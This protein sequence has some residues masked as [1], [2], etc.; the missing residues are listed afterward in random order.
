MKILKIHF[1]SIF[2]LCLSFQSLMPMFVTEHGIENGSRGDWINCPSPECKKP[3]G[4]HITIGSNHQNFRRCRKCVHEFCIQCLDKWF[5]Q[6]DSNLHSCKST[7]EVVPQEESTQPI[8]PSPFVN[9]NTTLNRPSPAQ[10]PTTC[11]SDQEN[12]PSRAQT[13]TPTLLSDIRTEHRQP[14]VQPTINNRFSLKNNK[15]LVGG[16]LA[17]AG[18]ASAIFC[19]LY[20]KQHEKPHIVQQCS[21]KKRALLARKQAIRQRIVTISIVSACVL[22]GLVALSKL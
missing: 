6:G 19:T 20:K 21:S 16:V 1:L 14:P 17:A 12:E 10:S 3:T 18:I 15:S 9:P 4:R 8:R 2:L 11:F 13:P 22:L 7:E 5:N